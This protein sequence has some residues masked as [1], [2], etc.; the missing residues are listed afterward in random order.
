MR[1]KL[2]RKWTQRHP[3]HV[4]VYWYHSL[5][6]VTVC[7]TKLPCTLINI[8]ITIL[9]IKKKLLL[10]DLEKHIGLIVT[11]CWTHIHTAY[12]NNNKFKLSTNSQTDGLKFFWYFKLNKEKKDIIMYL[13]QI[14]KKKVKNLNKFLFGFA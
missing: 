7:W 8:N 5:N 3:G 1:L 11:S 13:N 14:K 9:F 6:F 4:L 12:K 2:K 10:N